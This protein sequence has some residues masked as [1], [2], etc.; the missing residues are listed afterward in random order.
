[1]AYYRLI[2]IK[3]G[4]LTG[5]TS[6]NTC[7]IISRNASRLTTPRSGEACLV[8][9]GYSVGNTSWQVTRRCSFV[10]FE[11]KLGNAIFE[12]NSLVPRSNHRITIRIA[13]LVVSNGC[14]AKLH[15]EAEFFGKVLRILARH[16]LVNQNVARHTCVVIR[17]SVVGMF[18]V[19][20]LRNGIGYH[21]VI[22]NSADLRRGNTINRGSKVV[23]AHLGYGIRQA[24][25]Q[26]LG[27][28]TLGIFE[29]KR[30]KSVVEL[31]RA[32]FEGLI[33][34][35]SGVV[36][37]RR[38]AGTVYANIEGELTLMIVLLGTCHSLGKFEATRFAF[39]LEFLGSFAT[40]FRCFA[41]PL[42]TGI[43][44]E[45]EVVH[46]TLG[47]FVVNV[48]RQAADGR[49]LTSDQRDGG[50]PASQL[51]LST[52]T[53]LRR[54]IRDIELL[55]GILIGKTSK[56]YVESELLVSVSRYVGYEF[57]GNFQIARNAHIA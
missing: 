38:N 25:G 31:D 51:N 27:I 1:M 22:R 35:G 28:N 53:L 42:S 14:V 17:G 18:G 19:R 56:Y 55:A 4:R 57:L 40:E 16:L 5:V 54:S 6:V 36:V 8:G 33:V 41:S 15:L 21:N 3:L 46:A 44:L 50:L 10:V 49:L 39:V 23:I 9:F 11:R 12:L 32:I 26:V 47:Y 29:R 52:V 24:N 43:A 13:S 30:C 45:L 7:R 2:N 48:A 20:V 34:I 37:R